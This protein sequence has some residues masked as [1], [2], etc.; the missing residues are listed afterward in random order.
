MRIVT[1]L[2]LICLLSS[3]DTPVLPHGVNP[4]D[5]KISQPNLRNFPEDQGILRDKVTW[6]ICLSAEN[7][8]DILYKLVNSPTLV[9]LIVKQWNSLKLDSLSG[10]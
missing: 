2:Q 7:P 10:S 1:V 6:A 9:S 3:G 4:R 8:H 5:W